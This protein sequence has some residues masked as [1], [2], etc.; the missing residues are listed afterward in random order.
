MKMSMT[1]DKRNDTD[2]TVNIGTILPAVSGAAA[3]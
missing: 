2:Q 3:Y 1:P